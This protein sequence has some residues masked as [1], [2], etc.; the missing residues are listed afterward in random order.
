MNLPPTFAAWPDIPTPDSFR[1]QPA[2]Q[3]V[4]N[5]PAFMPAQ[6]IPT[7]QFDTSALAG[8]SAD[9]FQLSQPAA[10]TFQPAPAPQ[11][12]F[13]PPGFELDDPSLVKPVFRLPVEAPAAPAAGAPVNGLDALSMQ[14]AAPVEP[15]FQSQLKQM[16]H[17]NEAVTYALNL[18]TFGAEDKNGDGRISVRLGENGTF[19]SSIQKLDELAALGVNNIHLL[20]I[21]P[22]GQGKRFGEGGS[23][24][25]PSD[26][27]HLN[28]EFDTPGNDTTVVEEARQFI[29]EAHKRGIHVMVDVPSCASYDLMSSRPD[30]VLKG[31]DGKPLTPT[32]WVDIVMFQNGQKLQDYYEGFFD[33]MVNQIGVDGFRVDVARARPTEFWK[34]FISKYPDKAW[35]AETYTEEDSSPLKNLPRDIPEE[36]LKAGFDSIYGQFHIFHSMANAAEYQN[37]LLENRAMFQRASSQGGNDKSFIGSFLTHDDPSLMSKGGALMCILSSGLMTTQPFTNPYI[38][39]GF[40]TGYSGEFDIF[41]YRKRPEGQN[42]EIGQF[43]NAML[44]LRKDYGT[45]LTQGKYIPVPVS[46]PAGN[47]NSNADQVIAFAR[48]SEGRTLLVVA[49]KNINGRAQG[50]LN[51]PGLAP[52]TLDNLAPEYG[53]ASNIQAGNGVVNVDLGP[54]RFHVFEINTPNLAQQLPSY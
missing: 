14:P 1:A 29:A 46:A 35:L 41:N 16:F 24:Y 3:P 11:P 4:F 19:L 36:L 30:L 50:T 23:L 37:Y 52:Q 2:P 44:N 45:V 18:R 34:H 51:I 54:G 7:A 17:K 5:A 9:M 6:S 38:L 8:P 28:P 48:Q 32:N 53:R 42:P 25:A 12:A 47:P 21:N 13:V 20:P 10:P 27:H 49:N 40:T 15:P 26:Y 22:I 43:M 39:D 31:A 33:L